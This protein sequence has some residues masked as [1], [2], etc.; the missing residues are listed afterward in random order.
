[1][2]KIKYR[3]IIWDWN[4]TLFDDIEISVD[5]INGVLSRR[6]LP[7]ITIEK[8]REMFDF[9]VVNYYH[10]LGFDF[11]KESFEIVGTE[12]IANYELQKNK[13]ILHQNAREILQ[14]IVNLGLSQSILSAYKQPTL[15]ELVDTFDLRKF[16]IAVNGLNNHYAHSKVEIGK[17]WMEKSHFGSHEVLFVGDTFHDFE[18]AE[19]IGAD[20]VL[21]THGHHPK[22][23]LEKTDAKVLD[24]LQDILKIINE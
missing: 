20:C 14:S 10:K 12:F 3:H 5:V 24:S 6:N 2:K 8:Y 15:D 23:K 22:E 11:E 16:F 4:G 21:L 13:A 19:A 1:M 9:P 17:K 7:K 18:V